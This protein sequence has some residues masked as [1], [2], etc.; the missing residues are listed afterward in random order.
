M[1]KKVLIILILFNQINSIASNHFLLFPKVV[2][3]DTISIKSQDSII[4]KEIIITKQDLKTDKGDVIFDV[5]SSKFKEGFQ[6]ID[7]LKRMPFVMVSDQ[8]ILIK[9]RDNIILYVNNVK[10]NLEGKDMIEYLGNIP[11]DKIKRITISGN[12]SSKLESKVGG[13]IYIT[14]KNTKNEIGYFLN[15]SVMQKQYT[16]YSNNFSTNY[17]K[18]NLTLR[19]SLNLLNNSTI[20]DIESEF[21]GKDSQLLKTFSKV[22]RNKISQN[23]D[24]DYQVSSNL[25][26]GINYN[27]ILNKSNVGSNNQLNNNDLSSQEDYY[28]RENIKNNIL[29][30]YS[31]YKI[32]SLGSNL[33]F[34]TTYLSQQLT[35]NNELYSLNYLDYKTSTQIKNHDTKLDVLLKREKIFYE[36]GTKINLT[37]NAYTLE[38]TFNFNENLYSFYATTGFKIVEPI[39]IKIG[40]RYENYNYKIVEDYINR[41]FLIPNL[42]ISYTNNQHALSFSYNKRVIRPYFTYLNPHKRFTSSESFIQGSPSLRPS[43]YHD[44]NLTYSLNNKFFFNL[45]YSDMKQLMSATDKLNHGVIEKKYVNDSDLRVAGTTVNV[46]LSPFPWLSSQMLLDGL[47]SISILY[48]KKAISK[49]GFAFNFYLNTDFKINDNIFLSTSFSY[50]PS[51]AS[52]NVIYKSESSLSLAMKGTV[53]KNKLTYRIFANDIFRQGRKDQKVYFQDYINIVHSYNDSRSIGFSLNYKFG[54]KV[55]SKYSNLTMERVEI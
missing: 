50:I 20:S 16:N 52:L 36:F 19:Y 44:L 9:N 7:I 51:S 1:I 32:D 47:Y 12:N 23:L 17:N 55:K 48:D 42:L 18:N 21:R 35:D 25:N 31:S 29:L 11:T 54:K 10:I 3:K 41:N 2:I 5:W 8:D 37:S 38:E 22:D 46:L 43:I 49:S 39:D 40:L 24:L 33:S 45:Y 15:S 27:L 4:M 6:S 13:V 26:I 14:L 34:N 28:K 30:F 53:I